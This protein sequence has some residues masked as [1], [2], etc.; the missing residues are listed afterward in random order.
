MPEVKTRPLRV[1]LVS[2][3]GGVLLDL[4][5]LRPWWSQHTVHWAVVRAPDTEAAVR[6]AAHTW[7]REHSAR[8][9]FGLLLGLRRAVAILRSPRPDVVVSAGTGAAVPFFLAA[10]A[11][12]I[13]AFWV[14]TLNLVETPGIAARICA[15]LARGVLLQRE[16]MLA[17]HPGGIVIGELY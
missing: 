6:G 9:P 3:S 11:L 13:P 8:R 16:S 14:S 7:V 1:L 10:R 2:S 12:G 17:A 4:L 15:R 5:G